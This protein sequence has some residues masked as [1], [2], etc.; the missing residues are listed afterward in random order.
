MKTVFTL[1][2]FTTAFVISVGCDSSSSSYTPSYSSSS[3]SQV[4]SKSDVDFTV[5]HMVSQGADRAEA[6]A[7]VDAL[8]DAQREYEAGN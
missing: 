1:V 3:D 7:F 4:M 5:D 6:Q 8:N 2:I